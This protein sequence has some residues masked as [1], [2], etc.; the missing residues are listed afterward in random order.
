MNIVCIFAKI[1]NCKRICLF[2][3]NS[4]VSRLFCL[5]SLQLVCFS[6]AFSQNLRRL[7]VADGLASSAVT[8]LHQ[9]S[10]GMLWFGTLDGLNIYY[11][12]R[13]ERTEMGPLGYLGGYLI[14]RIVETEENNLWIQTMHG[15]H[16]LDRRTGNTVSFPEYVGNYKLEIAGTDRVMVLDTDGSLHVSVSGENTFRSVEYQ[17]PEEGAIA[18]MGGTDE[19]C[20]FVGEHGVCRYNWM[21]NDGNPYLDR[22]VS[23][24]DKPVIYHQLADSPDTIFIIDADYR[25]YRLNVRRNELTFI[26]DIS[27]ELMLKGMPSG[28]IEI[29]GNYL[30]SFKTSG[31][32][33]LKYEAKARKWLD[34]ELDI[35]SGVFGMIKDRY[36]SL[37]W[38]A[39]DGLGVYTYC[40]APYDIRSY[41]YSDFSF[42]FGKP[43]RAL[44]VDDKE[45]LW[46]GTKGEGL[47]GIDRSDRTMEIHRAPQRL[48]TVM[49]SKLEDN[50]VY[51]LSPSS[52]GGFW[53]GSEGGLNF[54][55]YRTRSLHKVMG[56]E[57]L[58]YVH[59]VHETDDSVLW[60]ATVGDGIYKA[61]VSGNGGS[62]RLD[63][64]RRYELM[65]GTMSSN[66][67]FSMHHSES[68]NVWFGNRGYGVY[69]MGTDGL[70]RISYHNDRRP[71]LMNDVFALCEHDGILW[72][73]TG[74]GVIGHGSDGQEIYIDHDD[75]LPNDIIRSLQMDANDGLWVA[76]SN[77]LARID[78]KTYDIRTYGAK[79][80]L[81]VTE[82]SD[83]AFMR[84]DDVLYFGAMNGWVEITEKPDHVGTEE[85]VPPLYLISLR[86]INGEEDAALSLHAMK[87]GP[88][89]IPYMELD[90][91][92]NSFAVSFMAM[93]YINLGD[94]RYWYKLDS[95]E[96]GVWI[97]NGSNTT[98]SL[99]QLSHG[100]H[101]LSVKYRNNITDYESD[102]VQLHIRIRPY[103][104]QTTLAKILAWMVLMGIAVFVSA[105]IYSHIKRNHADALK[106]MEQRHIKEVYEE[107]LRFF[108]NV[109]HEFSTPLTLILSP[110]ER[111]LS[112][113][114]ID[115]F[116]RKYVSLIKKQTERLYLLI[117]EIIDY[118][119]IETK[120]QQ[121]FIESFNITEYIQDAC[122]TFEVLAE[123]NGVVI[124]QHLEND[125]FWNM[126]RRC[127]PKIFANLMSNALKYTPRGGRIKVSLTR[128]T[129]KEM[130]LK[131]YNTGKGI[132]EED[133]KLIF[134]RYSVLD[135][136]E[137]DASKILSRN[138]LGMAICHSSV[139]LLE[140][141]IEIESELNRYAEFIVTL[142]L[143]PLTEVSGSMAVKDPIPFGMQNP[144]SSDVFH[145]ESAVRNSDT[146]DQALVRLPSKERSTVLV[147]D[148]NKD[149]LFL[150]REVL[151]SYYDVETAHNADEALELLKNIL[152]DLVITDVMMPGTDGMSLTR[153]IKKSKHTMH[154][155]VIVLSA[156]NTDED[157]TS[158][159]RSGAD[160]YIGKPFSVDYLLAVVNRLVESRKDMREYYNTSASAYVY[161]EGQL[162][163]TEDKEFM[164]R[165]NDVVEKNLSNASLTTD[166]IADDLNM[167][168]RSLY[169]RLKELNLQSP[170]E[171]V[172][173]RRMEKAVRLL[174]TSS[175]PIQEIIFECGFNN[176]AHF[177]KEFSKRFGMTPK[178]F[179][180]SAIRKDHS[181]ECGPDAL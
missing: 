87:C 82:F 52:Y 134:N 170:K 139:Q 115:D 18:W 59:A 71:H 130:Q 80:G 66:Y 14:E 116:V 49:N 27:H 85:Y 65:G 181:L 90:Q 83:G 70:D 101:T 123:K 62:L 167:S 171:Y 75:G 23:M 33:R 44:F 144:E 79:N 28:V 154:V 149:I 63:D 91:D 180:N 35:K 55:S 126:D 119:R 26:L 3:R 135:E 16:R 124:E 128:L 146:E 74:T 125:L 94:Y 177:Y 81:H 145:L 121:L 100:D 92:R 29:N 103:W 76:T 162:V 138:G 143:L 175:R 122:G 15:L 69:R 51:A 72:I 142:P 176:R 77:G 131:V 67:F 4:V 151:S 98:L 107:K 173:E 58:K 5:L 148:D 172:R 38:I 110:C 24:F 159:L 179:R 137:E 127:F 9:S 2:M 84:S 147:V 19:F 60:L 113:D 155:P 157:K 1:M 140:G 118:R 106:T 12:E 61:S 42:D 36:Q 21:E 88:S 152:P 32:V 93:D 41:T 22:A 132:R 165:L 117:Q 169:R 166:Q 73:G 97:D 39:T 68:G 30:L 17:L 53:V 31:V 89:E 153:H 20:W 40:D 111:V 46:I 6:F 13:V 8:S 129:D 99:T 43:V 158:G 57:G 112:H 141:R 47:I 133:R 25:L 104:W 34:E 109:T 136:V 11:G 37:V 78:T 105:M 178:D 160:V 102:P 7:T 150:L 168:S 174:Q 56:G 45:W 120:H 114:G 54:Y 10:D 50:S 96:D 64:L 48:L 86:E 108:T 164:Y 161:V 95:D 163:T 156:K